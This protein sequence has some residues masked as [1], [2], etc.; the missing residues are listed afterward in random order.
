MAEKYVI[1][2]TPRVSKITKV[3]PIKKWS[4]EPNKVYYFIDIDFENGDSVKLRESDYTVLL[5]YSVGK[6]YYYE[7]VYTTTIDDEGQSKT[8]YN[9]KYIEE[10][11]S[12][13]FKSRVKRVDEI[14]KYIPLSADIAIKSIGHNYT[15]QDFKDRFAVIFDTMKSTL[16]V[17]DFGELEGQDLDAFMKKEFNI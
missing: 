7:L 12:D 17:E 5:R 16:Y 6:R 10:L 1:T 14:L 15:E 3:S 8:K 9:F 4:P 2:D 13:A 11:M